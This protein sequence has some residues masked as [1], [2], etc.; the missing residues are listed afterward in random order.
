MCNLN[1]ST[2][3]K[4]NTEKANVADKN[5]KVIKGEAKTTDKQQNNVLSV[6]EKKEQ[7]NKL[8]LMAEKHNELKNSL[9]QLEEFKISHDSEVCELRINDSKGKTF[10]SSNPEAI[11]KMI[12]F[13]KTSLET[14]IEVLENQINI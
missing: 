2:A 1:S 6:E 9:K 8:F 3:K 12:D 14:K 13:C 4:N 7:I 10:K 11:S 5:L